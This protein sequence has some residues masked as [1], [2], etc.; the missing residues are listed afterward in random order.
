MEDKDKE[1]AK[2]PNDK[3]VVYISDDDLKADIY[4]VENPVQQRGIDYR[5]NPSAENR[6]YSTTSNQPFSTWTV[7]VDNFYGYLHED[8]AIRVTR[9]F[10]TWEIL[11][12]ALGQID[13]LKVIFGVPG[14]LYIKSISEAAA[15]QTRVRAFC[16]FMNY[17]KVTCGEFR[18][19]ANTIFMPSM[20]RLGVIGL[21]AKHTPCV[22]KPSL[23]YP[24][25]WFF[26]YADGRKVFDLFG[27]K[28]SVSLLVMNRLPLALY[29]GAMEQ[30][31]TAKEMEDTMDLSK[32]DPDGVGAHFIRLFLKNENAALRDLHDFLCDA[33][34]CDAALL[35]REDI[36][37]F[38]IERQAKL[39]LPRVNE[40]DYYITHAK[41]LGYDTL[42]KPAAAPAPVVVEQPQQAPAAVATSDP[43]QP[44]EKDKSCVICLDAKKTH[45]A[46]ECGHKAC[47]EACTKNLTTCPICRAPTTWIKVFKV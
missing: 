44:H 33:R 4:N 21:N 15:T 41:N 34:L 47:C 8:L 20:Q 13:R 37:N 42:L 18:L 17:A 32:T 36:A 35:L 43:V 25:K 12:H 14:I 31:F 24:L 1:S 19:A 6:A 10:F 46:K 28:L 45:V 11:C 29:A 16:A 7:W 30:R 38:F 2:K 39:F 27:P 26:N 23:N 5:S 40:R 9:F 3:E 22:L